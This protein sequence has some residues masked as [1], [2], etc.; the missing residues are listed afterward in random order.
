MKKQSSKRIKALNKEAKSIYE[1]QCQQQGP[2]MKIT[3]IFSTEKSSGIDDIYQFLVTYRN[4]HRHN[5]TH[6][7]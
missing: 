1:G 2:T 4:E 7:L 5:G 6:N 3:S